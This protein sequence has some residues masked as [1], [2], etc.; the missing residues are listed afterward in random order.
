MKYKMKLGG[1]EIEFSEKEI[2]KINKMIAE[3]NKKA[4]T[5]N[6]VFNTFKTLIGK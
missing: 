4:I 5:L 2:P 1:V 6:K 3:H